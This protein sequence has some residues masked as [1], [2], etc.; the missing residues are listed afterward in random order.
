MTCTLGAVGC[1]FFGDLN[2]GTYHVCEQLK[3]GWT[4][5]FPASGFDCDGPPNPDA[6]NPTP[7]PRGY[8]IH[9]NSR[10]RKPHR[11]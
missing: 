8:D 2:P 3:P 5:T 10:Q 11:K 6:D 9:N 1:Y 7:G 4:Q